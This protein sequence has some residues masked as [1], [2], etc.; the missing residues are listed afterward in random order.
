[1]GKDEKRMHKRPDYVQEE[2]PTENTYAMSQIDLKNWHVSM[3]IK[4]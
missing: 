3:S 2:S 1:M 4:L